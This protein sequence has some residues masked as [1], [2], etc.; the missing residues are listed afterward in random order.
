MRR[1]AGAILC[2]LALEAFAQSDFPSRPIHY[3]VPLPPGGGADFIA[4]LVTDR[5]GTELGR[6]II[7]ENRAGASGAI[8]SDFVA[9]APADGYTVLQCYVVTHGTNP[10]VSKLPYDAVKDFAPVGMIAATSN[11]L[12]VN[13]KAG[14]KTLQELVAA[15]R[16]KPQGMSFAST[17]TGSATHLTMEYLEQQAGIDLVHVPYKG[18]GPAMNDLLGGQVE[19]MF[20]SL[21]V[22][23]P[24]IRSGR[25][26][27]LAL[28]APQR[29]PLIPDVPTVAESGYP[30][31]NAVQWYGVCA[32]A[33]VPPAIVE[34][35]N[36]ALNAAIAS[37]EVRAKLGE[38][39]AD[40]M[41]MSPA[42]FG[43]YIRADIARWVKL[44]KEAHLNIEK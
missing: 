4:R 25:L 41:P 28:S 35:L 8:G 13:E 19:A 38:Q 27:A 17:G 12:V 10:A 39:A 18:A 15:L 24:H 16:A 6:P 21:I 9:K 32:P 30:A 20:P 3:V 23:L 33:G 31:F 11:V 34:R 2:A 14:V 22:A 44:L 42:E 43:A 1:I 7:V 26:R 29:S 5:M 37:S 36:R 40:V